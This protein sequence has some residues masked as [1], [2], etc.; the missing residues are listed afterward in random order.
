MSKQSVQ[1]GEW[2]FGRVLECAVAWVEVCR[3]R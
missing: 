1:R 3:N 2:L